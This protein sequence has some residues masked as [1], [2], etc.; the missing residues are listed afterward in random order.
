MKKT[1][2]V[3]WATIERKEEEVPQASM[4]DYNATLSLTPIQRNPRRRTGTKFW[5]TRKKIRTPHSI[6]S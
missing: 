6:N 5:Q 3:K 1:T 2:P 4:Y